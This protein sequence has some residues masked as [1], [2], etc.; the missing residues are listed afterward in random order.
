MTFKI[1]QGTIN[2]KDENSLYP[3]M[4]KTFDV[5]EKPEPPKEEEKDIRKVE[6]ITLGI[7][8]L[9]EKLFQTPINEPCKPR[10]GGLWAS[11][12]Q[13]TD[14]ILYSEWGDF[15]FNE[16]G[17]S[18]D[19]A[20]V[21][22]LKENARVYTIDSLEDLVNLLDKYYFPNPIHGPK[23]RFIDFRKVSKDYD[24]IELTEEGHW[25][26]RLTSPGLYGWDVECV[27]I[28]N[29]DCIDLDSQYSFVPEYPEE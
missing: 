8:K 3:S 17:K 23:K 24:V 9:D 6:L 22:K 26:T 28:L 15:A 18:Y 29:F 7:D 13:D 5:N 2:F 1:Q 20:C 4:M 21:Y 14:T 11:R 12:Y 16:M 19:K 10:V 25:K 27:L